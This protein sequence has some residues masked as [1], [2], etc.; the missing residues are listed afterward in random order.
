MISARRHLLRNTLLLALFALGGCSAVETV[1]GWMGKP[2]AIQ[3]AKLEDFAETAKFEVRWH[4]SLGDS[5][6]N[7]LQPAL[8]GDAVYGASGDGALTRIDRASGKQVWRVDSG[9]TISGGVGAGEGL[10]LIG[11]NKGDVLAYGEDG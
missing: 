7:V 4:A 8:T 11:S 10:V 3:P 9:I 6:A 1:Q 2:G 5:G